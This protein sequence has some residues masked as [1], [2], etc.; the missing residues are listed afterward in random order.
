[1]KSAL[2]ACLLAAPLAAAAQ[3]VPLS[4]QADPSV[5]KLL[6]ENEQFRV[7]VATWKPGQKDV[8]HSHSAATAYRLTDCKAR[9]YGA[10][11]KVEREGESK[12]GTA[13]IQGP[14]GAHSLE[15]IG[16]SDCQILIVERK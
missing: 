12:A 5:Y 13:S 14:V 16:T 6:A 2:L 8:P 4:Y 1:M 11:G 9:A 3:T 15:N 7:I 10:D